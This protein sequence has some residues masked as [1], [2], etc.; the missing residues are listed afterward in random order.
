MIAP[1]VTAPIA[2]PSFAAVWVMCSPALA[3]PAPGMLRTTI[4]GLPGMCR[5]QCRATARA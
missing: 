4:V 3:L 5:A 1:G 2:V